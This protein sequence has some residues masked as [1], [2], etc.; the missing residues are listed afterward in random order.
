MAASVVPIFN[1]QSRFIGIWALNKSF[2][3]SLGTLAQLMW[4][5]E[6]TLQA[7][8]KLPQRRIPNDATEGGNG[9]RFEGG[10][11]VMV[12]DERAPIIEHRS[13]S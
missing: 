7:L 12:K 6:P 11:F 13:G 10:V 3:P 4:L 9:V 5:A 8:T 1:E 2:S